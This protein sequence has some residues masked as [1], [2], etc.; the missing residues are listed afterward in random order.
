M[1]IDFWFID[2]FFVL[3]RVLVLLSNPFSISNMYRFSS[4]HGE[5][6][7]CSFVVYDSGIIV[8]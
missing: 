2:I 3:L 8:D 7:C 1:V 5:V 4:T 6:N